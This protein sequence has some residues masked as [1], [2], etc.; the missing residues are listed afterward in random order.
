MTNFDVI[1]VGAYVG[2]GLVATHLQKAGANVCLIEARYQVSTFIPTME[3][4]PNIDLF[5]ASGR[6]SLGFEIAGFEVLTDVDIDSAGM[7]IYSYNFPKKAMIRDIRQLES[8]KLMK[9][10]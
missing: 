9:T 5:E 8:M 3:V 1:M 7:K 6:L 2:S 10:A 4:F